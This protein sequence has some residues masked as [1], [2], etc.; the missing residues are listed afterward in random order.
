MQWVRF[1]PRKSWIEQDEHATVFEHDR[2]VE[3]IDGELEEDV[4]SIVQPGDV[5][6]FLE[7][8]GVERSPSAQH[9]ATTRMRLEV[10][11]RSVV[12][13]HVEVGRGLDQTTCTIK[14]RNPPAVR[15]TRRGIASENETK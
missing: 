6:L 10:G 15:R 8:G 4:A 13:R 9:E 14:T 11:G 3:L 12:E 7:V 2:A 5:A 1:A